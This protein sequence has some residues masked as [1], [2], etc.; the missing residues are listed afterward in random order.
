ME[1]RS[2]VNGKAEPWEIHDGPGSVLELSVSHVL[3]SSQ[4]L[5]QSELFGSFCRR[6]MGGWGSTARGHQTQV[7]SHVLLPPCAATSDVGLGQ[8][9]SSDFVLYPP[10]LETG[11]LWVV[12]RL[13][14]QVPTQVRNQRRKSLSLRNMLWNETSSDQRKFS[15]RNF[16]EI[17]ESHTFLKPRK[18]RRTN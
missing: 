9:A 1:P 7:P 5:C 11:G 10:S 14:P 2:Q 8:E 18:T 3:S 16:T 15:Q 13:R 17:R 6:G 4:R 12:V